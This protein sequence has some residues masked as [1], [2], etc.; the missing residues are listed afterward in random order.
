[1]NSASN[2]VQ[3]TLVAARYVNQDGLDIT[4]GWIGFFYRDD[5]KL[6]GL[7]ASG[8]FAVADC[9]LPPQGATLDVVDDDSSP[10]DQKLTTAT[11]SDGNAAA[12]VRS[13]P[14]TTTN[15]DADKIAQGDHVLQ[16]S[17][18]IT[19]LSE[20]GQEMTNELFAAGF[21]TI[22]SV[23]NADVKDLVAKVSGLTKASAN[24][25]LKVASE[26]IAAKQN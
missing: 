16:A 14:S 11:G 7:L 17:D 24:Q 5:P 26:S 19:L 22:G 18:S 6:V 20:L 13:N 8:A 9:N 23:I 2:G 10:N 1:M 4:R 25:V 21:E 3:L 15:A 12:D